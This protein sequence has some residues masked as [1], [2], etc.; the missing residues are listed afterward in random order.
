[1]P[2]FTVLAGGGEVDTTTVGQTLTVAG[3]VTAASAGAFTVG[4]AGNTTFNGA[5]S[6]NG[7]NLTDTASGNVAISGAIGAGNGNLTMNGTGTLTLSGANTYT[8]NGSAGAEGTII[9]SGAVVISGA[10]TLGA[11]TPSTAGELNMNSVGGDS[12]SLNLGGTSQN[13]WLLNVNYNGGAGT[14]TISNGSLTST[15][16]LAFSPANALNGAQYF[17]GNS[18]GTVTISANLLDSGNATVDAGGGIPLFMYGAGTLVLSGANTYQGQTYVSAGTVD[19]TNG[20]ASA[21][22]TQALGANGTLSLGANSTSVSN[23]TA[24]SA[25]TGNL[26]Y[27]GT[28]AATLAKN[29][30]VIG[31]GGAN[32]IQ[33]SGTGLL[34]LSGSLVKN[35]TTLTLNGGA[36][37]I[38]VTGVISGASANSDMDVTGGT[39]TLS[40]LATY[41]GPTWIY[42]G[43]V[44]V[45]N[46]SGGALPTGTSINLGTAGSGGVSAGGAAT[47]GT[48]D[49]GGNNQTVAG[50]NTEGT[51]ITRTS[52]LVTNSV[53]SSP[54][55]LTVT[56]GGTFAGIIQ[57]GATA[58]NTAL[59]V[60][61]GTLTLSG[62][63]TYTGATTISAGTLA[64]SG[65]GQL[66][67]GS[68]A[69]NISNSGTF[70]YG[71]SASQT[72]SG[73][74]SGASGVLIQNGSGTLTLSGTNSYGGTTS[75][76]AGTLLVTGNSSAV[77]GAVSVANGATLGGTGS[78][79]GAVTVAGG[80]KINL[81]DGTIGTLTVGGL[82]TGNAGTPSA[83]SF[84][85]QTVLGTTST[86]LIADT[87]TLT[88]TG[89]G[90]TTITIGNLSGTTSLV[91][92]NYALL[93]YTGTT[94]SLSNLNLLTT[95]LGSATLSLTQGQAGEAADTIYLTVGAVPG[96]PAAAYYTGASGTDMN[97]AANFVTTAGG[98]TV[99]SSAIGLITDVYLTANSASNT[100]P[101]LNT[102]AV[103]I[104]SLTFTGTGTSA[105]AGVTLSGT[106]TLTIGGG[107]GVNTPGIY[108]QSGSG[109]DT[110]STPVALGVSQTWSNASNNLLTVG[111]A[112]SGTGNL[113]LAANAAG[114]I[115]LSGASVNN[116]GT[117]T[118]SGSGT[119]TTTIS[120]AIGTNVTGVTQ[121]SSGSSLVLSGVNTYTANT[122]ISAGTLAIGGAGQL[123]SGSYAGA[124]SNSGTFSYGSSAAQTLS[125]V[126]SGSGA[127]VEAGSGTLTLS[128]SSANTYTGETTVSG[129]E[130]D[131]NKSASVVAI[132]GAGNENVASPDINVTG[133]LLKF[134][135]NDQLGNSVDSTGN[136]TLAL[137]SGA[138]V[139]LHGTT[140]TLYAYKN[141]GGTIESTGGRGKLIGTGAT[142]TFD[143]GSNNIN[144][145][146]TTED[147]HI[148]IGP[149]TTTT[150]VVH[151]SEGNG[152]G[153]NGILQLDGGGTGLQFSNGSTL[154]LNSDNQ[155]AGSLEL[156]GSGATNIS[157]LDATSNFITSN[158]A[159]TNPGTVNLNTHTAAFSVASGGNLG[160]G[161][162]IGDGTGGAGAIS[163]AGSGTLTL[164]S[165]N[166]YSGGTAVTG[167]TLY[168][169]GGVAGTS[170]ATGTGAITVAGSS[171]LGGSGVIRPGSGNGITI[172]SGGSLISGAV[173]AAPSPTTTAGAGLTLDNTVAAGTILDASVGSA[174]LTFYLGAGNP[175]SAGTYTFNN[176]NIASSYMTVLG[177][178][179]GEIKF[180]AGDTITLTD[181]TTGNL[182]LNLSV[183]YLLIQAGTTPD[184][185][186]DNN[187]YSGLATT[188][189]TDISGNILNGFVTTPLTLNGNTTGEYPA[190]RLY[191]YNGELEVV[192]E[193]GTWAMMLGGFAL[194]VF[195]QRRKSRQS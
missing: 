148:A 12:S 87:G 130:L 151:G 46:V 117:L 95:A 96:A 171:A 125:G 22:G 123:G 188:G 59:A 27:T 191:L 50:L 124:I 193:P 98:P 21:T 13:V 25:A 169:N 40:T 20:N 176:P 61:G 162:V 122:T 85:I 63:N 92:G 3:N 52:D 113:T 115:T 170:S 79:G 127:L 164:T 174:N 60:S 132:K 172:A 44:L 65:A 68:Y 183:P 150:V 93:S 73:N 90:G 72:L 55:T 58:G 82:S 131:L 39:T 81:R 192:P 69:G 102:G 57:D 105:T 71:S 104:N 7:G 6:L 77:T 86:D 41:N 154:Q 18:S 75:I 126:I 195:I 15:S 118:N 35:G 155:T 94:A 119:G 88:L 186:A 70:T 149:T 157:V 10:G 189:G 181:L 128:G 144:S 180:A 182:Q 19:F 145:N 106:N 62:V 134:L 194:L 28:G 187:L 11:S 38:N 147:T 109:A 108:I 121:N 138:T 140:Q 190:T 141:S 4:G 111:G 167:G 168:A 32:T 100:A 143:G 175:T 31:T 76:N 160:I 185:L 97:T 78:L 101:T 142:A 178:T 110:I 156:G 2:G 158:G 74:I 42:G 89:A 84:D 64:I 133:G 80:G 51:G 8:G 159:N 153:A 165:A 146:T 179:V 163:K 14:A 91:S 83:F 17:I 34:T 120:A 161:A 24:A 49:L 137:S 116:S 48:F 36:N 53:A 112:V 173:Q 16:N 5:V 166:T 37:G 139:D 23:F 103:S 45:N 114:G 33:N 66:G 56:N 107:S 177:N 47:A 30:Q 129:G 67:G 184:L 43:G 54:N 1:M 29:I 135:A 152:T 99:T 9:N 26:V 136:V